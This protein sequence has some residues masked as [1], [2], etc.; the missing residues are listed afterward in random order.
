MTLCDT[1]A[2]SS[3]RLRWLVAMVVAGLLTGTVACGDD[4]DTNDGEGHGLLN[5]IEL[6]TRG[7]PA[8]TIATWD[9]DDG[10]Q[11]ADGD[12]IDT[13]PDSVQEDD[14]EI[15]PLEE[16]GPNASLTVRYLDADG[17]ELKMNTIDRDDETGER[18]CTE[19]STRYVTTEADDETDVIAWPNIS[20][21]DNESRGA[22]AQFAETTD[23]ELVGL[24][25]CDHVYLH[26]EEAGSVDV[27]F[28]L[29]HIDHADDASDP[30]T[31]EVE[32]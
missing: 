8:T 26:P 4:P 24:F 2:P 6:E 30:L 28:L 27:E 1:S 5:G 12:D 14:G 20:H 9:V 15:Y 10:W 25:H 17:E 29:W 22:P 7:A 3:R 19:Y 18:E 21:P 13:L 16:D 31:I 11:N 32:A 23:G